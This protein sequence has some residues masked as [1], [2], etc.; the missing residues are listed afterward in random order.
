MDKN[1]HNYEMEHPIALKH[2]NWLVDVYSNSLTEEKK[3]LKKFKF[4]WD[5]T[6]LTQTKLFRCFEGFSLKIDI[7]TSP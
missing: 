3:K 6:P 5:R 7:N 1:H 4:F 2:W